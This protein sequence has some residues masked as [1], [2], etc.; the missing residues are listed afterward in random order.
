MKRAL[1]FADLESFISAVVPS[2]IAIN[3]VIEGAL[4]AGVSEV[5]AIAEL[6]AIATKNKVLTS[7]IGTGYYGTIVPAVI[8]RNVLENP[9]WYTAYTPYQPEISQGRLEALFAFQTM[10][11]ELTGLDISNASMLDES[12][13]AAEAMTLARRSSK[14]SDQAVFLIE[15]HALSR[16]VLQWWKSIRVTLRER[17]MTESSS[18]HLFNTRIQLARLLI[19]QSLQHMRTK[20]VR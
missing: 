3:G 8:K 20:V 10:V 15:E 2:N 16:L 7:L 14:L 19:T 4:D 6:K 13:A 5:E 12:T 18:A 1:G 17:G 9:A 11:C